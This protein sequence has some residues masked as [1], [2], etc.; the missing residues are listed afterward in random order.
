VDQTSQDTGRLIN[1]LKFCN[2]HFANSY[3]LGGSLCEYFHI[4][5]FH[6]N[7]V[8]DYDIILDSNYLNFLK[9][10]KEISEL[11]YQGDLRYCGE[12]KGSQEVYKSKL[13]L[14]KDIYNVDWIFGQTIELLHEVNKIKFHGINTRV[15]SR[16]LRIKLLKNTLINK[17]Q[18]KS[19][20]NKAKLRLNS[21]LNKTII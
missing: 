1:F 5:D 20:L 9:N 11:S 6:L 17:Q 12:Q 15:A 7:N 18:K 2:L 13:T 8:N 14:N 16:D 19:F 21:Y 3:N 10:R 4:T